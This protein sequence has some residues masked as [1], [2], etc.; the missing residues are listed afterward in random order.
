MEIKFI[1]QRDPIFVIF[2]HC[3]TL[4]SLEYLMSWKALIEKSS[5]EL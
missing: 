3:G 4:E 5:L 1:F 2:V